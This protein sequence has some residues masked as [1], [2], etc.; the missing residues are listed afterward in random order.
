MYTYLASTALFKILEHE[1]Q[2]YNSHY[3]FFYHYRLTAK[4]KQWTK[5]SIYERSAKDRVALKGV[6]VA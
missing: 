5:L 2:N 4:R 1:H 3:S 6:I